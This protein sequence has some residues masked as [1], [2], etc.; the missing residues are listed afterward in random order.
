MEMIILIFLLILFNLII[1]RL[2]D[3]IAKNLE[4]YDKPDFKRKIHLKKIPL[5][6][7]IFIFFNFILISILLNIDFFDSL[8]LSFNDKRELIAVT[9]L[10]TTL[11]LLGLYDDRYDISA[12]TKLFLLGF[13]V[14]LGILID[15]N[16]IITDLDFHLL[17]N[18]INLSKLSIP[19]SILFVL[20]FINALNMFDGID[21]Q[22][23]TYFLII[24]FFLYIKFELN[25]L[26][27]FIPVVIFNCYFN[28]KKK[29]FLGDSGT[30]IISI[31]ISW[32]IMRNYNSNN[33]FVC[34]E[35][36]IMMAVP[37]LDMLR[38]FCSRI[39]KGNNPFKADKNH[40][41]HLFLTKFDYKYSYFLIQFLVITPLIY[42]IYSN[43]N[44]LIAF[45]LSLFLYTT[46]LLI[47]KLKK[48]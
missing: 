27:Y 17:K 48:D 42:Y 21:M 8:S 40:F 28:Y 4:L 24:I 23:S 7:G 1:F 26:I 39:L 2:N 34:E 12:Y 14:F 37:G 29:L 38:L 44:I 36:F 18:S 31:L 19:L 43:S 20:L 22:V 35:I 10:V 41:H 16:I 33:L 32:E 9:F 46:S 15:E 5:T 45:I 3:L 11:F 25:Y 13:I 47:L 6:G 30:N